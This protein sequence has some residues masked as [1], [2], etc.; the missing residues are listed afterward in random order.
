MMKDAIKVAAHE[1]EFTFALH[2]EIQKNPSQIEWRVAD[3]R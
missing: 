3:G 2:Y 1:V